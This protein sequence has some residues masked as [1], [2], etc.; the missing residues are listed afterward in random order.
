[1]LS[2]FIE[3]SVTFISNGLIDYKSALIQLEEGPSINLANDNWI[4]LRQLMVSLSRLTIVHNFI[5]VPSKST[6]TYV[7]DILYVLRTQTPITVH[8]HV[9]M[10]D[11][12]VCVDH[13]KP[14]P[15]NNRYSLR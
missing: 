11:L 12:G 4:V 8:A 1:M 2:V 5:Q 9:Y 3:M 6:C 7:Y 15:Q 13:Y 10:R 14:S